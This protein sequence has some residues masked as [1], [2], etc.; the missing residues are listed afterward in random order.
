M[1]G[2]FVEDC[3]GSRA[4]WRPDGMFA[5]G[6]GYG[7]LNR[8][9]THID[10]NGHLIVDTSSRTCTRSRGVNGVPPFEQ[11]RCS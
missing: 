10:G 2:A 6:N 9:D 1:S 4:V 5:F 8:Y 3:N 7:D 11:Q